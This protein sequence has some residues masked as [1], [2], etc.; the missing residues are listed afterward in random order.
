MKQKRKTQKPYKMKNKKKR[1]KNRTCTK[2]R[3]NYRIHY[4]FIYM[5]K[6]RR[7]VASFGDLRNKL[8]SQL[9]QPTLISAQRSIL[10]RQIN[11][12]QTE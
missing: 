9:A 10:G 1:E 11:A 7:Y 6:L 12:K 5:L 8:S 4:T 2:F 3:T